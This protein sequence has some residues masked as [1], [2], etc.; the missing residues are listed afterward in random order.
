[1][2]ILHIIPFSLFLACSSG[3]QDN[4]IRENKSQKIIF[5]KLKI[6][7]LPFGSEALLF[8]D[9]IP[10]VFDYANDIKYTDDGT[11]ITELAV[12]RDNIY[13]FTYNYC[14]EHEIKNS[15][16]MTDQFVKKLHDELTKLFPYLNTVVISKELSPTAYSVLNKSD[17]L[18]Y[19]SDKGNYKNFSVNEGN[20]GSYI[21]Y[22]GLA[23]IKNGEVVDCILLS[24][25]HGLMYEVP[26]RGF[27][28][29]DNIIAVQDI[30]NNELDCE[31]SKRTTYQI[32]N[33][34]FIKW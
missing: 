22:M 8:F 29:Y 27:Y 4:N 30:R 23:T 14:T 13:L 34:K 7:Q 31:F 19:F 10:Q 18:V 2:N 26:Y 33:K 24:Y 15:Y 21:N 25:Y 32:K 28:I 20:F 6:N 9:S 12:N 3:Q 5:E 1:M 11:P 16:L 17:T